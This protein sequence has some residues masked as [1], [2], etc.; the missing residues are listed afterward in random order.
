MCP[1][2]GYGSLDFS[3]GAFSALASMSDGVFPIAWKY[4]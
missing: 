3:T 4:I 2:C 1:G